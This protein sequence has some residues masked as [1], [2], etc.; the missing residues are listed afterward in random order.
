[1]KRTLCLVSC[2]QAGVASH[3]DNMQSVNLALGA[4]ARGR[5]TLTRAPRPAKRDSGG[6]IRERGGDSGP[7][8]VP[9]GPHLVPVRCAASTETTTAPKVN[10]PEEEE[11]EEEEDGVPRHRPPG[12]APVTT[13]ELLDC[14]L[15]P[16]V[17]ARVT[18]LLLGRR[19]GSHGTRNV[20][21]ASLGI[22]PPDAGGSR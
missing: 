2:L 16:D 18:E 15:H 14:L 7:F 12:R 11:E 5:S 22:E 1:V 4:C 19:T 10:S 21:S 6:Q 8:R 3:Q 13:D 9:F 20:W 17:I